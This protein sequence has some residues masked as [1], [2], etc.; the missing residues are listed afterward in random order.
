MVT[1]PA[2]QFIPCR[3]TVVGFAHA[4]GAVLNPAP[5]RSAPLRAAPRSNHAEAKVAAPGGLFQKLCL[6]SDELLVVNI[7]TVFERRQTLELTDNIGARR[8]SVIA[9]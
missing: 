5:T 1:A 8:R 9:G 7:A 6:K 2:R 3:S 4:K